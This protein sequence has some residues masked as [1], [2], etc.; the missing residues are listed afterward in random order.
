V[1]RNNE[2]IQVGPVYGLFVQT[3]ESGVVLGECL[4][5][6]VTWYNRF[7]HYFELL[8]SIRVKLHTV[9]ALVVLLLWLF[10][11]KVRNTTYM[12]V[13]KRS[14]YSDLCPVKVIDMYVETMKTFRLD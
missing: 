6:S 11:V 9:Y 7:K 10:L 5:Y 14:S 4:S 13:I 3:L 1:C 2:N 12:Y 8:E